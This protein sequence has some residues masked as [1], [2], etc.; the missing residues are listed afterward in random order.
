MFDNVFECFFLPIL[1]TALMEEVVP[2]A[3][4]I[5]GGSYG[6]ANPDGT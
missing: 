4:R 6:N 1:S 3:E 5:N 2:G